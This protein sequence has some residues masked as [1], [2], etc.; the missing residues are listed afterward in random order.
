[1][2]LNIEVYEKPDKSYLPKDCQRIVDI[3]KIQGYEVTS[4][5]AFVLWESYSRLS[6]ANWLTMANYTDEV[7]FKCLKRVAYFEGLDYSDTEVIIVTRE[8]K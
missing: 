5:E 1:M 6:S 3:L 7:I 2:A 4:D 8:S